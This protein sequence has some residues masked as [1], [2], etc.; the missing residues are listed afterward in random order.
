MIGVFHRT[1]AYTFFMF[2]VNN[3]IICMNGKDNKIKGIKTIMII[4]DHNIK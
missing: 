2:M 3:R 4:H 1:L